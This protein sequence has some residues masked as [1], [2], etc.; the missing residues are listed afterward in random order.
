MQRS[1]TLAIAAMCL[2]LSAITAQAADMPRANP[3]PSYK[4][5]VEAPFSWTGFYFGLN[6]GYAWGRS[7]WSDPLFTPGSGSFNTSGGLLGGQL[8]YN[9][10]TGPF[11]FGIETDADWTNIKG[12]TAGLGGVCLADG[13]GVCQTK[14]DW[15]GTTRGRIGYAFGRLMPYVTGGAAYGD[16]KALEATGNA[17][18]TRF[19]WT[20][21]GGVEYSLDR[22]W[23][24]KLEYLH[25]DLGTAT[26]FGA[27]AGTPSLSV[28]VTDDLVRA[29]I[30]YHW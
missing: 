20:A 17:T 7:S 1:R 16:I 18:Q 26:L 11:V 5:P 8:G 14:Q 24:A 25:L 13:A 21:G 6:G 29:G 30:N 4:A 19:G 23:S 2:A 28:P 15:F 9:W 12:S 3:V 10:Q 27:A 22:N